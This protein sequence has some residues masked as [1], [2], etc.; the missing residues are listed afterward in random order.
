M[1]PLK[2]E[3]GMALW[4]LW[5][6]K[7]ASTGIIESILDCSYG[8]AR[9]VIHGLSAK[10]LVTRTIEKRIAIY[11]ITAAL[12]REHVIALVANLSNE[13]YEQINEYIDS[14]RNILMENVKKEAT[15]EA[16]DILN[17]KPVDDK[18]QES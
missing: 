15:A 1:K 4:Y 5:R 6:K 12:Q 2:R 13:D 9:K 17:A 10:G 11:R 8:E 18:K 16:K 14:L 3:E 7:R